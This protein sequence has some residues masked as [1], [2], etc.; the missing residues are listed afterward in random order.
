MNE[1]FKNLNDQSKVLL[2]VVERSTDSIV[3]TDI[4]GT[5]LYV[6]PTFITLSGYEYDEL[7]G[8]SPSIMKSGFTKQS[9]Y[10]LMWETLLSG[11]EFKVEL[12]NRKK[13]GELFWEYSIISP[14]KNEKGEITNFLGIKR[15]ITKEKKLEEELKAALDTAEE[16][17]QLKLNIINNISHEY[18]T[19]LVGI[20][21]YTNILLEEVV[22]PTH[23]EMLKKVLHSSRRL[24]RTLNSLIDYSHLEAENFPLALKNSDISEVLLLQSTAFKVFTSEKQL[25][26]NF[27]SSGEKLIV[28]IDENYLMKA[29]E[30]IVDN[31]IKFTNKGKVEIS[32]YSDPKNA[33][34]EITDTGIGISE[35]HLNK[36]FAEFR[37]ASE[38]TSRN[39]EG[40]GIGLSIAKKIVNKLGGH[41]NLKSELGKGSSFILSFPLVNGGEQVEEKK[42]YNQKKQT[43]NSK[44]KILVVE[45]NYINFS[46]CKYYL[47]DFSDVYHAPDADVCLRLLNSEE[48]DLVLMDIHLGQGKKSGI[49]LLKEMKKELKLSLIPIVA[50][51]GYALIGDRQNFLKM[52]F[53][54]YIEKP[55][56]KE[57]FL[58]IIKIFVK[59]EVGY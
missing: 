15:D 4:N 59:P 57:K 12:L 13:N 38:G 9:V 39:F 37:Q 40:T 5:I 42:F 44:P 28:N 46:V 32:V 54:E 51:T 24:M 41:I 53:D 18:R 21:G 16:A 11:E 7:I 58:N 33:I 19:P 6:N 49:D 35:E 20:F 36:I 31:A 22:E 56:D 8:K 47:K 30:H 29:V 34:I 43:T 23:S 14:I 45:D 3:L 27:S 2:T 50:V 26:F 17:N 48:I 55:F 52:G 25:G 1:I 10:S